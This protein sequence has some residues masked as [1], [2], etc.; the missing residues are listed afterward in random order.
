VVW[1]AAAGGVGGTMRGR[2]EPCGI[3]GCGAICALTGMTA[4]DVNKYSD[5]PAKPKV[6]GRQNAAARLAARTHGRKKF[7][8]T[9]FSP[10]P[11]APK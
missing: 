11:A 4:A 3:G 10:Y 9:T 5:A 7:V 6:K 8:T 2:G 1:G